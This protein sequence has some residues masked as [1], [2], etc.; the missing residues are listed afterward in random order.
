M[1][2]L[3]CTGC[4]DWYDEDFFHHRGGNVYVARKAL[5]CKTCEHRRRDK[6]K[7]RNRWL[8]KAQ[9]SLNHHAKKFIQ[10]K[11]ISSRQ[12]LIDRFGWDCHRIAH[13]M[14]HAYANSCE[15]CNKPYAGMPNGVESIE[16]DIFDPE[17][18]PFYTSNVRFKCQ[19]CN[20]EKGDMNPHDYA[21]HRLN[22]ER[23][24]RRFADKQNGKRTLFE[25]S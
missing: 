17:Q 1:K 22:W 14:A 8:V 7:Q 2:Q 6:I 18:P 3:Y 11:I 25:A 15:G 20:R 23:A 12:E 5:R 19:T 21:R 10:S 13:D 9:N 16:L 24:E 4:D